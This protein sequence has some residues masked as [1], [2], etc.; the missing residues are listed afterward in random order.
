MRKI[1]NKNKD[2]CKNFK[3]SVE[4]M[5]AEKAMGIFQQEG[6]NTGKFI[7]RIPQRKF[8]Y[9]TGLIFSLSTFALK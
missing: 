6:L 8:K 4:Q 5:K 1:I 7:S 3:V 2:L 9:R